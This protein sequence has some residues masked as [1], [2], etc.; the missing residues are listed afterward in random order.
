M[1]ARR[2][3]AI[4]HYNIRSLAV[5][6]SGDFLAGVCSQLTQRF[7]LL[8]RPE[9]HHRGQAAIQRKVRGHQMAGR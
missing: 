5:N 9:A 4:A 3:D 8:Q 1:F 2:E 6:T 7:A